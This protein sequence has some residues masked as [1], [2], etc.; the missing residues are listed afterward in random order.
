MNKTLGLYQIFK[1]CARQPLCNS[2]SPIRNIHI[3]SNVRRNYIK[4]VTHSHGLRSA[5]EHYS[6]NEN[7]DGPQTENEVIPVEGIPLDI[8]KLKTEV[9]AV[10]V[11]F[12]TKHNDP[13]KHTI[14]DEGLFYTVPKE[15]YNM[16]IKDGQ[17]PAFHKQVQAFQECALMVRRPALE[18]FEIVEHLNL[19]LPPARLLIYGQQGHGKT[20][21]LA[22][23]VHRYA[24]AGWIT[25]HF[26]NMFEMIRYHTKTPKTCVKSF[27]NEAVYDLA[28]EAG[29][30]LK[31]FKTQ[32]KHNLEKF[33]TSQEYKW[34][35]KESSPA[36]TP[37]LDIV[38][39]GMDRVKFASDIIG[40]ILKELRSQAAEKNIKILVAIE[41]VNV[42]Y[43]DIQALKDEN[44][45]VINGQEIS[46]F[47][48]IQ[49][50]FE[51]TWHGGVCVGT[52]CPS[53]DALDT[54]LDPL[55]VPYTPQYLL[56]QK[57]FEFM[58]PFIPILVPEFTMKEAY[59]AVDYLIDRKWIQRSRG[60]THDGKKELI[61]L[62][63]RHPQEMMKLSAL[64]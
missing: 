28:E 14:E 51:P 18:I 23:V 20:V 6:E 16:Y 39:L 52:V 41:G 56:K 30:W 33:T 10:D 27:H 58:D 61:L 36:G 42:L 5:A 40:V 25:V 13:T 32:N 15:D 44:K 60:K 12:R 45:R 3:L 21:T 19:K 24:K 31:F 1:L 59:N 47:R 37:L 63:N 17:W 7:L 8:L 64:W 57:G 49:K 35:E 9:P 50:M 54:Q 48:N 62:S 55:E 29:A 4:S 2:S 22:H 43:K 53:V 38:T 26:P 46:V 11:K 34:S